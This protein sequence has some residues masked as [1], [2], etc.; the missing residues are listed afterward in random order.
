MAQDKAAP[1]AAPDKA[2]AEKATP[3]D[4][5]YFLGMSV[6][7]QLAGQGF[8]MADLTA[9][10]FSKGLEDA[11]NEKEPQM[12]DAMLQ[13]CSEAIEKALQARRQ[14]MM[15]EMKKAGAANLKKGSC[16]SKRMLR[17]KA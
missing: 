15:E 17:R 6:G 11:L 9:E 4:V 12:S 10:G 7:Q 14:A 1:A 8:K 2:A 13:A 5:G 3:A 16:F